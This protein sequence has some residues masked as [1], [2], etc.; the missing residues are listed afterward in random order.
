MS[1]RVGIISDTHLGR[2]GGPLRRA[3]ALAPLW[4]GCTELIVN[5][6]VAEIHHHRWRAQAAREIL[7]LQ[8]GCDADGVRLTLLSGNHDPMLSDIRHR[9]LAGGAV[10]VMHGDAV[11]PAVA[12]W[13]VSAARMRRAYA[14]AI[15]ALPPEL[16][17]DLRSRLEACQHA[18][19]T[20]W[21][22]PE[23]HGSRLRKALWMAARPSLAW[24]VLRAWRRFPRQVA[25]FAAVHAPDARSLVVGHVHR[26]SITEV[27]DRVVINT[28]SFDVPG[29]PRLAVVEPGRLAVFKV[30]RA[31][32]AWTP[33]ATPMASLPLPDPHRETAGPRPAA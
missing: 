12:P 4:R 17:D 13:A 33:A 15:A 3:A 20:E 27:G 16:R 18:A 2:P 21:L 30:R 25:R 10:L 29:P 6:D 9:H 14:G 1:Y 31:G 11:D 19:H 28:G 8:K 26:P 5:G 7:D 22:E 32:G 23:E 24:Q